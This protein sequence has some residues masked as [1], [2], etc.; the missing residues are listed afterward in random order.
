MKIS[1]KDRVKLK[2]SNR[3]SLPGEKG[4]VVKAYTKRGSST[5]TVGV[6]WEKLAALENPLHLKSVRCASASLLYSNCKYHPD[7]A[8]H[9]N[10]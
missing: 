3:S 8:V 10:K 5:A 2:K 7:F 9:Q 6:L 1:I 4:T